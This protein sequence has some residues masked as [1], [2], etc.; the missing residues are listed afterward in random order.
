M[1]M[2]H[3]LPRAHDPKL[4]AIVDHDGMRFSYGELVEM[5]DTMAETLA[6]H[7]LRPG[8]RLM[9]V[10]ENCATYAVA[11]LAASQIGAWVSPI[12][13][14]QSAKELE[15]L[16]S[17]SGARM[18]IFTPEA[19]EQAAAHA[20]R[21]KA[22]EIGQLPC[23]VILA[24]PAYQALPEIIDPRPSARIAVLMY[25]TGTTS[26]PKGVMLSQANLMFAAKTAAEI[27]ALT[28]HDDVIA[29]LPGTHIF[30]LAA[31]FLGTI[32]NGGTVHFMPRFSPEAVLKAFENGATVFP[33]VP[34]MFATLTKH[35]ND[36][37][38]RPIAPRLRYISSGGAPL[39]PEFKTNTEAFFG[40]PLHNGYGLTETTSGVV[41]TTVKTLRDDVSVG[42][43]FPGVEI[44]IGD[45]D[46]AGIGELLIRAPNVMQGYYHNQE[47]TRAA[48]REDGF[49]RSGD[50]ARQDADGAVHIV[51]RLKELII[52]S[53]F[54]V[55]PP[56][57]EAMLTKHAQIHQ[58]A[59][60]GQAAK[61]NE[62]ILAFCIAEP[63]LSEQ[64]VKDYLHEHLIGYKIP[65]RV[66]FVESF[67]TAASGK[68]LKRHLIT[69]FAHLLD[70]TKTASA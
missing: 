22:T 30:C 63:G 50:L 3:E 34:Q 64:D 29:V 32:R 47:A 20:A 23:G 58:A 6:S 31:P 66:F 49:F 28:P 48:I 1:Q 35:L 36:R 11:V 2:L 43:P 26:A 15:S 40:L 53:G 55:F 56:E 60:V 68:I 41:G 18:M 10:C 44:E 54:N 51:G 7:G 13:A 38:E 5:V 70:D 24:T 45:K 67:P 21:L 52:R 17:H 62:D 25:T 27:R 65:Q 9:L 59:V 57:I 42:T 69:E 14:R 8:D 12:N 33:A 16:K 4:N 46:E 39:D 37:S 19:S 61:G